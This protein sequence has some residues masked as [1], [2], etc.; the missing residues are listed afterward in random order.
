MSNQIALQPEREKMLD[1]VQRMRIMLPEATKAPDEQIWRAAQLAITHELDPFAGDIYLYKIGS[2][3]VTGVGI[4]GWRRAAQR[5]SK[6]TC[7]FTSLDQE[8]VQELRGKKYDEGDRGYLCTLWRL[9]AA[10]ECHD[11]GIPYHPITANGIYRVKAY[12]KN[13][14]WMEDQLPNCREPLDVA[15]RR[16]EMAAIKAAYVLDI[17]EIEDEQIAEQVKRWHQDHKISTALMAQ[18]EL[19]YEDDGDIL[20]A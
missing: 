8:R 12:K 1:V 9:D 19:K 14:A 13:G 3:W 10:R 7:E 4:S 17:P 2:Y 5:Q 11:I 6:Y 16:S 20:F 18:K 15:K